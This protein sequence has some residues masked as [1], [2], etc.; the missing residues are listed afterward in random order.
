MSTQATQPTAEDLDMTPEEMEAWERISGTTVDTTKDATTQS[1]TDEEAAT[2]AETEDQGVIGL[3]QAEET[4]TKNDAGDKPTQPTAEDLAAVAG[5]DDLPEIEAKG[6]T[7]DDAAKLAEDAKALRDQKIAARAETFDIDAKWLSGELSDEERRAAI[8]A[9]N[10]KIDT[11]DDQL[12]ELV[13]QQTRAETLA[14]ATRQQTEREQVALLGK[15]AQLGKEAGLDYGVQEVA[16]QFDMALKM[17]LAKG[18]K[19]YA[20]AAQQ[21]HKTVLALNGIAAPTAVIAAAPAPVAAASAPSPAATPAKPDRKPPEPPIT[22]ADAPRAGASPVGQDAISQIGAMTDPDAMEE[23]IA[24][25]PARQRDA[26][27]RST[28]RG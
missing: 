13:R 17:L 20:Q 22:L 1:A 14:E 25:M 18:D 4:S 24:A 23:M 6:Y 9:I 10:T 5:T 27:F 8:S 21:A 19:T 12:S 11:L 2:A 3:Q 26:L 15:I 28:V 16:E 7:T